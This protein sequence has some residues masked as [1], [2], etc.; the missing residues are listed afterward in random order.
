MDAIEI[1]NVLISIHPNN[2]D[3]IK[4]L[5]LL[6]NYIYVNYLFIKKIYYIIHKTTNLCK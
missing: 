1:K 3:P 6:H 4:K 5:F 2:V